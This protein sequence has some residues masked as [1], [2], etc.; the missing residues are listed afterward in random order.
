[1]DS[2]SRDPRFQR[3]QRR[4]GELKG[5]YTHLVVFAVVNTGLFLIDLAGGG[6]WWFYWVLLGWG[7]GLAI[8]AA[9]VFGIEGPRGHSWEDRKVRELMNRDLDVEKT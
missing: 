5:F 4:F 2:T 7:V 8:H 9:V 3:A 1:M 6:N